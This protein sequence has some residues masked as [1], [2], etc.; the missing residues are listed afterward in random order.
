M[1][2]PLAVVVPRRLS[3]GADPRIVAANRL[4]DLIVALAEDVGL[5]PIVTDDPDYPLE[6]VGGVLLPGGGDVNPRRYGCT[7]T[8]AVYDVN[9]EQD[10]L[11]FTLTARARDA[12]L[13]ILG[14]CRG[15]QVLNVAYGGDLQVDLAA[16]SVDHGAA[17][18]N[19]SSRPRT[20]KQ[21]HP[22]ERA[23]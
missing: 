2:D 6:G 7:S 14:I 21:W 12:Q 17:P 11:D 4:F 5:T 3:T 9:D 13:P 10:H 19:S 23:W 20:I 15:A 16:G 8:A 18:T 1:T 22:W